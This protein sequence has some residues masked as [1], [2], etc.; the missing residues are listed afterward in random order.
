MEPSAKSPNVFIYSDPSR[1]EAFGYTFD[2]WDPDEEV[3]LY[4]GE[5]HEGNQRMTAGNLALL[6]HRM[7]QRAVR[8]F[9]ADGVVT[10]TTK[11][12]R[13]VGEFELDPVTPYTSERARSKSSPELRDVFVFR[14]L[15]VG[16]YLDRAADR[17]STV[18]QPGVARVRQVG[19]ENN[20]VTTMLM[21]ATAPT[22]AQKREA[23]LVARYLAWTG[24]GHVFTRVE[25]IPPGHLKPL[26][27]DIYDAAAHE[28]YEVK[29]T[30]TREAVRMA[31]GQLLDYRRHLTPPHARLTVLLPKRPSADLLDLIGSVGAACCYETQDGSFARWPQTS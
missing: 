25:I 17:S 18:D 12:H 10:G 21:P 4:T 23:E 1:G 9:V 6:E 20:Q 5:G 7:T 30:A 24:I 27:T 8:L 28:L 13:Y 11:N 31:V 3:F 19:L 26:Y 14:L 15:P 29:A 16:D 2:G 22:V